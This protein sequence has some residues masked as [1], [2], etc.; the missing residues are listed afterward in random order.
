MAR[1]YDE[2]MRGA[3]A[4]AAKPRMVSRADG[5]YGKIDR[6]Q[7]AA[8]SGAAIGAAGVAGVAAGIARARKGVS[9]ASAVFASRRKDETTL[10]LKRGRRAGYRGD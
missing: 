1:S 9:N 8:A 5:G 6:V 2:I 7:R 4:E 10:G 3:R